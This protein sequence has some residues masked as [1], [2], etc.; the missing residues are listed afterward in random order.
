M[1]GLLL[2][3]LGIS[4]TEA[5][6][7]RVVTPSAGL[8]D[9]TMN[10][11][12]E[13]VRNGDFESGLDYW[14]EE[15]NN[16][17]GSHSITRSRSYRRDPHHAVRIYKL[18]RYFARLSQVVDIQNTDVWFSGSARLLASSSSS[19]IYAYGA[20]ILEYRDADGDALGRTMLVRKAGNYDPQTT[21]T[22]HVILVTGDNW[23]DYGFLIADELTNL[24][25]VNPVEV[26]AINVILESY[27]TG[28]YG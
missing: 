5:E 27:G 15:V 18:Q 10:T 14:T 16:D 11:D 2:L 24:T 26:A 9:I 12:N 7:V 3:L 28:W 23:V 13:L 17:Q 1:R 22:Q 19:G 6:A 20:L 21:P 25:G 8:L 4:M